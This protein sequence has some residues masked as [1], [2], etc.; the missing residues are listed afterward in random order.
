MITNAIAY[1]TKDR[2]KEVEKYKP[3]FSM[4]AEESEH[5]FRILLI[6]WFT[7]II[8]SPPRLSI[9]TNKLERLSLESP[10]SLT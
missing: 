10:F 1:C 9:Q 8:S 2:V 3:M 6:Q 7:L 5:S 4:Q